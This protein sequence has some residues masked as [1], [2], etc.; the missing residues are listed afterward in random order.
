MVRMTAAAALC[1]AAFVLSGCGSGAESDSAPDSDVEPGGG[2]SS[3]PTPCVVGTWE[4]DV[5]DYATQT[6]AY[7]L[8]L[9]IPIT[10]YAM[11]GAGTIRF[12]S[13]GLVATEV[14]LT[15]TGTIVAGETAVPLNSRS[16]YSGSGDWDTGSTGDTVDLAN[17]ANLP[18]PEVPV[19]PSAP[20]IPTIDYTDIPSVSA[21][22]SEDTL[23]LQGPDAPF[24]AVWHR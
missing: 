19:D 3:D 9:G 24:S 23:V 15:T 10:D 20:S 4:L 18:S 13:D 21:Q 2:A 14:D 5:P 16:A 22:C 8:G 12:T 1:A 11:S 7:V 6:E 17:W